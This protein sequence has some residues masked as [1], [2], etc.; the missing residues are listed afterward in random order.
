[1]ET[2]LHIPAPRAFNFWRTVFSHGWCSLPPFG[3]DKEQKSLSRLVELPNGTLA[4]CV[5]TGHSSGIRV[6]AT[7]ARPLSAGSRKTIVAQ[8]RTCVR[9]DED[10]GPFYRA[11]R[12]HREYAWIAATRSGR[13]LRA[14]TV[15]EDVVKMMCTTN[16]SW[17]L[18]ESMVGNLVNELGKDRKSVV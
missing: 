9:L 2:V 14:P 12:P 18:T 7:H 3:F 13:L 6:S 11:L 4:D 1:M 15:F 17:S 10:F 16:C 5:M 8:V